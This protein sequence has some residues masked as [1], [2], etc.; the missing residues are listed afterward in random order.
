MTGRA[1][2]PDEAERRGLVSQVVE[3]DDLLPR[4]LDLAR[5]LTE[6]PPLAVRAAKRLV[7][8]GVEA[9]LPTAWTLEQL[10]LSGLYATADAREGIR[11]F[12][13][14]REPNFTGR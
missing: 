4:A 6:R 11:A 2:R 3:P 13:D 8:D 12:L 10:V 5:T 9:S 14:K 1:M 7:D